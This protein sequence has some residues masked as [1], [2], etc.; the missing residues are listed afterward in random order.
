MSDQSA[1]AAF[2]WLEFCDP[3]YERVSQPFVQSGWKCATDCRIAI[4]VKTDEPDTPP[5]EGVRRGFPD[6]GKAFEAISDAPRH[7]VQLPELA[8][9]QCPECRGKYLTEARVKC[10]ECNGT[11][12]S[13]CFHCGHTIDCEEC[14]DGWVTD[15]VPCQSCENR[16]R[17]SLGQGSEI[18]PKYVI[19]MLKCGVSKVHHSGIHNE[20]VAFEIMIDGVSGEGLVSPKLTSE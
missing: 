2:N 19:K 14:E 16:Y 1:V 6:V 15:V 7:E 3:D 13:E 5:P 18:D 20:P 11:G 8:I 17:T 4:R 10:R 9:E 12:Q